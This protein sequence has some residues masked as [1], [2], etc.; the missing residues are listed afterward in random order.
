M[1]RLKHTRNHLRVLDRRCDECLYSKR[2]VVCDA[3]RDEVLALCA[4]TER[5]FGCHKANAKGHDVM[6]RGHWDETK[7]HTMLNRLAQ[8]LNVVRFVALDEL[9]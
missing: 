6:C 2:K 9:D 4:R 5:G 8:Q 1:P 7:D 3:R